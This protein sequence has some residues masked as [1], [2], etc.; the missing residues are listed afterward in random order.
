[1][2][3]VWLVKHP[4]GQYNEDVKSLAR[5]NDLIVYDTKFAESFNPESIELNPPELTI[6]GAKK[7]AKKAAK[8]VEEESPKQ[9]SGE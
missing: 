9:E 5:K 7:P 4:I 3:K 8:K 2:R 6:K 1:M